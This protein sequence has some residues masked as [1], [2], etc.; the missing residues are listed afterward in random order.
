MSLRY[1]IPRVTTVNVWRAWLREAGKLGNYKKKLLEDKAFRS[2]P[3]GR[4]R[5]RVLVLDNFDSARHE[6]LI[7]EIVGLK[8]FDCIVLISKAR[9]DDL[10]NLDDLGLEVAFRPVALHYLDRSDVR[11]LA[12]QLYDTFDS[13]LISAAVEKTYNDLLELCIPLTP[14]NVVMYVSVIHR[15]GGFTRSMLTSLVSM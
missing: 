7:K 8:A 1:T 15:E 3:E 13:D 4:S 5:K 12:S 2:E 11:T 14:S 9:G 6:R 10:T